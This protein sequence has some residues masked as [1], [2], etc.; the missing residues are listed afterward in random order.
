MFDGIPLSMPYYYVNGDYVYGASSNDVTV[1]EEEVTV[2]N[3]TYNYVYIP[4]EYGNTIKYYKTTMTAQ[5]QQYYAFVLENY[6]GVNADTKQKLLEIAAENG[7]YANDADIINKV[8]EYIRTAATYNL[9]FAPFPDDVDKVIY[10]LTE[11]KEGICQHYAAAATLMFRSLGIPARYVTGFM[12]ETVAGQEVVVTA[13]QC[14]AWVEVYIDGFGWVQLEVTGSD[15]S[16]GTPIEDPSGLNGSDA[17]G[18]I[19]GDMISGGEVVVA[20]I[21]ANKGTHYLRSESFG[22]FDGKNWREAKV[23]SKSSLQGLIDADISPYTVNLLGLEALATISKQDMTVTMLAEN[24]PYMLPYYA[25]TFTFMESNDCYVVGPELGVSYTIKYYVFDYLKSSAPVPTRYTLIE[26][27]Y[28]QMVYSEYTE[29]SEE[30]RRY[31]SSLGIS[32]MVR[33]LVMSQSQP[34]TY[35]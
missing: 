31:F 11:A 19:P 30:Y 5:E 22:D 8:V 1:S 17:M 4:Y 32:A 2:K 28:R 15:G 27:A 34:S 3:Q 6:L 25:S 18:E 33:H 7:I 10:F 29:V 20:E 35:S 16:D 14:H 26:N 9:S 12:A 21:T 23:I 13:K 24:Y